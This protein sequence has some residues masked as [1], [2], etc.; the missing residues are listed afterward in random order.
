MVTNQLT[1]H[2]TRH[3][4][5]SWCRAGAPHRRADRRVALP[6]TAY[7]R[8][9]GERNSHRA[10]RNEAFRKTAALAWGIRQLRAARHPNRCYFADR[11]IPG[12]FGGDLGTTL[13]ACE[14]ESAHRELDA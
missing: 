9:L 13:V 2:L 6:A 14:N 7:V 8:R 11:L 5:C 12:L 3:V 10:I 1:V 4:Q